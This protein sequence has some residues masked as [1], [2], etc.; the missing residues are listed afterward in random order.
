[1]G[2]QLGCW[3]GQ[4]NHMLRRILLHQARWQAPAKMK[5]ANAAWQCGRLKKLRFGVK[6]D[7]TAS[8]VIFQFSMPR[9]QGI[10]TLL[11]NG[12]CLR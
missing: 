3:I 7:Q 2:F 6:A 10:R 8:M 4:G 11:R 5:P 9:E 12:V 1:M